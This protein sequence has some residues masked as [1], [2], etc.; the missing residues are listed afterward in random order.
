M[1]IAANFI[2][3]V[4]LIGLIATPIYFAQKFAKVAGVK[5]ESKYLIVS[6]ID[7]FPNLTF[8]Q[9]GDRYTITYQKYGESQAFLG[10]LIINNP[11]VNP[12]NYRLEKLSGQSTIFFGEDLDDQITQISAPSQTSVPISIFSENGQTL[13][14]SVEF[15]IKVD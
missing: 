9:N 12:Q 10:I 1:K 2:A 14:Q 6:Q 13:T 7:K 8:S 15:T 4:L 5:S 3:I 11:T